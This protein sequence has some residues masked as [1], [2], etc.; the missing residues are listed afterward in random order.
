MLSLQSSDNDM[1]QL[2]MILVHKI[3]HPKS[4][5]FQKDNIISLIRISPR[6][7]QYGQKDRVMKYYHKGGSSTFM[8]QD[9]SHEMQEWLKAQYT[10]PRAPRRQHCLV[11]LLY[12]GIV[13]FR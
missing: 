1:P 10:P 3:F 11:L 8:F 5:A 9:H 13:D 2:Q 7:S 6:D 12:Y 4:L